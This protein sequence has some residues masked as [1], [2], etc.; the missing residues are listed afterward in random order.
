VPN[1]IDRMLART[2]TETD[3]RKVLGENYL[4]VFAQVWG[5]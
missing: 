5:G 2:Y 4:R 3:V 1:F